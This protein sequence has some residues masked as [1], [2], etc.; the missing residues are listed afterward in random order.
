MSQ[1]DV[2]SEEEVELTTSSEETLND[3]V[4]DNS[5]DEPKKNQSNFKKLAQKAKQLRQENENLRAQLAAQT[6][7]TEED[8]DEEFDL[9]S[10]EDEVFT[11]TKSEIW[12]IKNKDAE[13]YRDKM[14]SL[15]E[16][17][18]LY[19]KLPLSDLYELAKAKF[20]KSKSKSVFDISSSRSTP[21]S[22]KDLSTI[23]TSKLTVSEI[24]ALSPD[25]YKK[26]FPK[27]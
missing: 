1:D 14:A 2:T 7:S 4:E 9:D 12:F 15:V 21:A 22:D 25:M 24:N 17:K 26:L 8:D 23:D 6:D 18:P 27:K 16:D 3:S 19:G 5:H 11:D 10:I 20:P 13:N